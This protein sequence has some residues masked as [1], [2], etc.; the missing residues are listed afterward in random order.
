MRKGRLKGFLTAICAN[1]PYAPDGMSAQFAV[2]VRVGFDRRPMK[3]GHAVGPFSS[4]NVRDF[5]KR[6]VPR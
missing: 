4:C 6:N 5:Q 2:D 1:A 3:T